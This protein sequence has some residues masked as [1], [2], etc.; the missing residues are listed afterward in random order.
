MSVSA[1][2]E[3]IVVQFFLFQQSWNVLWS[4]TTF[5]AWQEGDGVP[6]VSFSMAEKCTGHI[7]L[8]QHDWNVSFS[9][10]SVS[11]WLEYLGQKRQFQHCWNV[12]WSK[13]SVSALLEY[14]LVKNDYF[15]I[16]GMCCG[17]KCQ[18]QHGCTM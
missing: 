15:S 12:L 17:L 4:H 8:C 10:W 9:K 6:N 16:A 14:V 2:V 11:A 5:Q 7:C 1:W 3:C 13:M 18:F